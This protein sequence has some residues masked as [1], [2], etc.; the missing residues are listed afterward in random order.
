MSRYFFTVLIHVILLLISFS[1]QSQYKYLGEKQLMGTDINDLTIS[2]DGVF[3]VATSGSSVVRVFNAETLEPYEYLE[4]HTDEVYA[5]CFSPDNKFL[6]TAGL[7]NLIFV[8]N[9]NTWK[10]EH[11]IITGQEY[12]TGLSFNKRGDLLASAAY[13]GLKVFDKREGWRAHA[14]FVAK[15][16]CWTVNFSNDG[17]SLAA[18]IDNTLRLWGNE[19]WRRSTI[20]YGPTNPVYSICFSPNNKYIAAGGEDSTVYIMQQLPNLDYFEIKAH[21]ERIQSIAFSPDG[22][23][24]ITGGSDKILKTW[25][26]GSWKQQES[27]SLK[28][29]VADIEIFPAE[30]KIVVA[31][32]KG[33]LHGFGQDT[34]FTSKKKAYAIT[35]A[36]ATKGNVT[37]KKNE[38]RLALL[39]GNANYEGPSRLLNPV[40]DVD[41]LSLAFQELGF[42]TMS[43]HN[44]DFPNMNR[45]LSI[46][47]KRLQ[48]AKDMDEY[49][50]ALFYY[51][52]HGVQV[53]GDSYLIPINDAITGEEDVVFEAFNLKRLYRKLDRIQSDVNVV[54]VDACRNNP[55][56][57][58]FAQGK[59]TL[60]PNTKN[61]MGMP[62]EQ[63]NNILIAYS[64]SPSQVAMDGKGVNSPYVREML[65]QLQSPVSV[66]KL[67][68]NVRRGVSVA[69]RGKQM[70]WTASTL[71]NDFSFVK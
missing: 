46:F 56:E 69:T 50:V 71:L 49:V 65:K 10:V 40:K 51:S 9:T 14:Q 31:S 11:R 48:K 12:I 34:D 59:R 57:N 42:E 1:A 7:D 18:G 2:S 26:V 68:K 43:F 32:A 30:D 3:L 8:W 45:A 70:P 64:T 33:W 54:V 5:A 37:Q 36:S 58:R 21:N 17:K 6:A 60:F 52:G 66:E 44:L 41:S 53:N 35:H 28:Y 25:R 38:R 15:G 27:M 63:P 13:S 20:V 22:K 47:G 4:G 29:A 62:S 19:D 16:K 67:F 24:L 23:R 61:G 39:I 55:F